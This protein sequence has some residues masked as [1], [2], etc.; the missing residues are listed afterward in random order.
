MNDYGDVEDGYEDVKVI[1]SSTESSTYTAN[2]TIKSSDKYL[3][4][5]FSGGLNEADAF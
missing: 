4:E 1:N 3:S 5:T 2:R